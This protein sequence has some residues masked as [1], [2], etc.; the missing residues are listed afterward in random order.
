MSV[1]WPLVRVPEPITVPFERKLTV[2]VGVAVAGLTAVRVAVKTTASFETGLPVV[3]PS[4]TEG[5]ARVMTWLKRRRRCSS[6]N[7]RRSR[8]RSV[9]E[10]VPVVSVDVVKVATPLVSVPEPSVVVPSMNVT[11]PVGVGPPVEGGAG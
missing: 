9:I 10:C 8:R 4:I 7:C 2:P 3:M 11:E 1:A 5:T 6:C